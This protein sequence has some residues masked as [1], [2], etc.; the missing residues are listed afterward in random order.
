MQGL[1]KLVPGS[2]LAK[3]YQGPAT[4]EIYPQPQRS[5][6]FANFVACYLLLL[7]SCCIVLLTH[8][9]RRMRE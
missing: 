2:R 8:L 6:G 5:L 9:C 3:K 4:D 1:Y 7:L